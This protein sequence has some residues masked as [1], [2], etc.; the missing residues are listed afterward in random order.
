MAPMR[1]VTYGPDARIEPVA[2]EAVQVLEDAGTVVMPTDTG[3]VL[4]CN[5][6]DA[7]AVA[8][9]FDLTRRKY[10]HP[11]PVLVRDFRWATALGR[12]DERGERLAGAFWPGAL[13]LVVAKKDIVPAMTTGGGTTIG[14]RAPD[15]PLAQAVLTAMGYPLCG[16]AARATDDGAARD[17]AVVTAQL[18]RASLAPDLVIDSGVLETKDAATVVDLCG[19]MPRIARQGALRADKVLPLL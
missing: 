7:S 9:V 12:F 11:V 1:I 4:S 6:L 16:A 19:P 10:T 15:H 8:R 18:A 13:I 2:R 5:A 17:P 14:L 3:Y